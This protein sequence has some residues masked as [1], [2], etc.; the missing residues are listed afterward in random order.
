[1]DTFNRVLRTMVLGVAALGLVLVSKVVLPQADKK[2]EGPTKVRI[3]RSWATT[4]ALF[5]LAILI[6]S[7]DSFFDY[8][9]SN[10]FLACG[11]CWGLAAML[12]FEMMR[13]GLFR[14]RAER[15]AKHSMRVQD[16][17]WV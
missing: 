1:M 2:A 17:C 10:E 7:M 13:H 12:F 15:S 11:L 8:S 5:L 3:K 9:S 16:S 14:Q 6:V 4:L